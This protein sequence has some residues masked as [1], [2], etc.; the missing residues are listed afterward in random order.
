MGITEVYDSVQRSLASQAIRR[1]SLE[2][3]REREESLP[4]PRRPG[5]QADGVREGIGLQ[6]VAVWGDAVQ[7]SDTSGGRGSGGHPMGGTLQA[8]RVGTSAE[9]D[10]GL[11]GNSHAAQRRLQAREGEGLHSERTV[12]NGVSSQQTLQGGARDMSS[13]EHEG[14][15]G[16]KMMGCL[17][18]SWRLTR[19][20]RKR[21]PASGESA[22]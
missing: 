13:A 20:L 14:F 17:P 4:V 3:L 6:G 10:D 5:L 21:R 18:V 15:V 22:H 9:R 11:R 19:L 7:S 8:G 1:R 2:R 12:Q 16:V